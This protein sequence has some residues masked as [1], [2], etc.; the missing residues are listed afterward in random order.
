M[1]FLPK[2][3]EKQA[4]PGYLYYQFEWHDNRCAVENGRGIY[5]EDKLSDKSLLFV[6]KRGQI[7]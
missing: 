4:L 1:S 3:L 2:N 7:H 6:G 5:L